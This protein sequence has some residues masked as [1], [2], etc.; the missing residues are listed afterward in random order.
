MDKRLL[1]V[2]DPFSSTALCHVI[3]LGT[4]CSDNISLLV[5]MC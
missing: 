2:T 5:V 4:F 3:Y 1:A